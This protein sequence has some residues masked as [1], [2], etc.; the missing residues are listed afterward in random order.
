MFCLP[1]QH[2]Q[3]QKPTRLLYTDAVAAGAEPEI[4]EK[5]KAYGSEV[6]KP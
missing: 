3:S 6:S 2:H 4:L 5:I 1:Y